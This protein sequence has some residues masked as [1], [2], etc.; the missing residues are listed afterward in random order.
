MTPV[1][2]DRPPP[3]G[4]LLASKHVTVVRG[5]RNLLLM[6]KQGEWPVKDFNEYL[7]RLMTL[8]GI[9]LTDQG[10]PNSS[11]FWEISDISPGQT[12]RWRNGKAQPT[13]DSLRK[14]AA[15]LAPK[16]GMNPNSLLVS[17]EVKAGRRSQEEANEIREALK[18]EARDLA[19]YI[20]RARDMVAHPD[21]PEERRKEILEEVT[22]AEIKLEA[23]RDIELSA[24]EKLR[25]VLDRASDT[26]DQ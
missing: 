9:P 6:S 11:V 22:R 2:A 18:Q 26:A 8:A 19:G 17:L 5:S 15:A 14:V 7:N 16:L 21:L 13:S 10:V 20:R 25:E 12:S 1:V 24:G 4:R 23:A 3:R